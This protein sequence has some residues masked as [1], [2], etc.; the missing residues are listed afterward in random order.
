ML[1]GGKHLFLLLLRTK[2]RKFI[3]TSQDRILKRLRLAGGEA[4]RLT[5]W[6]WYLRGEA[7]QNAGRAEE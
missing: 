2:H 1:P 6:G 3:H 4:Q 7:K 5:A